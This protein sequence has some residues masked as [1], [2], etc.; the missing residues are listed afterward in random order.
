V[1]E[2]RE[3][4]SK[5]NQMI[6]GGVSAWGLA[7]SY[8]TPLYVTDEQALRENYRRI[9]SAFSRHMDTRIMYACKA[10][11]NLAILRILEQEGSGIDAVSIGE[12][13]T[14]MKA[15]FSPDRIL[16]T[17]VNVSTEELRQVVKAGVPVNVDSFSELRRLAEISTDV[18]ISFRV[19]PGVGS[20]HH[21]K[22]VTGAK[23]SKFGIP[24]ESIIDAY[25]EALDLGFKPQGLHA[26]IGSGGQSV[27]P[28][29]DLIGIM[30]DTVNEIKDQLGLSLRFL[31]MGG[32]IGVPYR[33]HDPV[34][35]VDEL[36]MTITDMIK[37]ET[38]V[39]TLYVEPGRYIICDSTVLLTRCVDIKTTPEKNFIG[40]DAGFNT[41]IRP[42]FYDSYHHVA[43]ANKFNRA[44]ERKFDVVGP[45]CESG[46]YLARDR[47]LPEPEEGDL[48]AVYDAGA[49]GFVMSSNYNSRPR[50]REALVNQ[51]QA[52]LIRER[53]DM[54]DIWRH[55][56]VPGRLRQ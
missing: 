11:S 49:Y 41:L 15:G 53:E 3:F 18:P 31:D 40:V 21:P 27:E 34:M 36:A 12:V 35:E 48:L 26:H 17:G 47:V 29:M 51:G 6:I 39:E 37:E 7:E 13:Q 2:V 33:P 8:G 52:E 50:C 54:D 45:I 44:C 5:D 1:F 30:I 14:C 4:E 55:Q 19:T 56:T 24:R 9:H 43:I 46:D 25:R 22:V 10:N 16:Y 32:G 23:G 28:F 38:E 42:A 20:G